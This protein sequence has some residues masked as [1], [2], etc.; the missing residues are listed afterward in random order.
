MRGVLDDCLEHVCVVDDPPP[1]SVPRP[2]RAVSLL[3]QSLLGKPPASQA[4][5]CLFSAGLILTCMILASPAQLGQCCV[6]YI[7][8]PVILEHIKVRMLPCAIRVQATDRAGGDLRSHR[9]TTSLM[10]S[11]N[12]LKT[13]FVPIQVI[14]GVDPRPACLSDADWT[15][16][17]D[18]GWYVV[19]PLA[20]GGDASSLTAASASGAGVA[21]DGDG[22]SNSATC[23]AVIDWEQIETY[24]RGYLVGFWFSN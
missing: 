23:S 11:S 1:P 19:V 15:A 21:A 18:G 3:L 9:T 5:L 7:A 8:R 10:P 6:R 12:V 20:D 22:A 13:S 4:R 16:S 17:G 24:E 2:P 14:R